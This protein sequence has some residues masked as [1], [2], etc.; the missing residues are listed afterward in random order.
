ME[1]EPLPD[2][3]KNSENGRNSNKYDTVLTSLYTDPSKPSSFS[4]VHNLYFYAKKIFPE[5]RLKDVQDFLTRSK[6]YTK[7][8]K[9]VFK[10]PRRKVFVAYPN[11]T[12]Q[13]DTAELQSLKKQN[14]NFSYILFCLDQF[15]RYLY[16]RPYKTKN[17]AETIE[18]FS[19][20]V[21]EAGTAP[22]F[23]FTDKG[24]EMNFMN[25]AFAKF[26]V[27]RYH[28]NSP[29]KAQMVERVILSVKRWLFKAMIERGTLRYIDIL[30][31]VVYSYNHRIHKSL[32]GLSP[33]EAMLPENFKTL[34]TAFL[35]AYRQYGN[36]FKD[37]E[38]KFAVND[39]V[40]IVKDRT[41]FSRGFK[42]TFSPETYTINKVFP[43]QPYTFGIPHFKRRWYSWQLVKTSPT[44]P[45]FYIEEIA[46]DS[47]TLR[48]GKVKK[49]ENR[50][51][52]K[53]KN[54]PTY[55]QW[56]DEEDFRNFEKDHDIES[57][58]G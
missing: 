16:A 22:E 28:V 11:E 38:P 58:N 57:K 15:S 6:T 43:S 33:A 30:Q 44:Q 36:Q 37:K 2:N 52:I 10:G 3:L 56:M 41:K 31:D 47:A 8:K 25:N 7:F 4:S 32:F 18:V 5:I 21:A 48:S 54:N 45:R 49:K 34:K 23:C 17:N 55:S 1:V 12:W 53:D 35:K 51:L 46:Q 39:T 9:P 26:E 14:S 50:F 42:E 24:T 40:R 29:L 20:I 13:C 27:K 19:S